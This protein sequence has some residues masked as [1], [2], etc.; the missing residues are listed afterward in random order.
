MS[1]KRSKVSRRV[2]RRLFT[3]TAARTRKKNI[4]ALYRGGIRL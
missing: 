4:T 1:R 3:K 2:S